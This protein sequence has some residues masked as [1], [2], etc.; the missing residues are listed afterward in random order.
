MTGCQLTRL[1]SFRSY[2][3]VLIPQLTY[4]APSTTFSPTDLQPLQS[5]IDAVYLPSVGLNRHFPHAVLNGPARYG[6][7]QHIKLEDRQGMAQ[8]RLMIGSIQKM[9]ETAPLIKGSLEYLQLNAGVGTPIL[10]AETNVS[11]TAWAE[12][13]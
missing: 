8:V 5:H 9:G 1:D 10:Q 12:Q 4:M 13:G 7:V 11:V 2:H 6:G 3:N